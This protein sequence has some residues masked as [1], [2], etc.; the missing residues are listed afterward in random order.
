MKGVAFQFKM[1]NYEINGADILIEGNLPNG[2]GLSSSASIELLMGVILNTLFECNIDRR[3]MAIMGRAAENDFVGMNCGVMD[4]Y[5]VAMGK[6]DCAL[7]LNC[8][9]ITHEYVPLRID[10]YKLIISNTNVR[11]QLASSEYNIRRK[12]S[13][14]ALKFLKQKYDIQYLCQLAP[15][16]FEADK[17]M[18]EDEVARRRAE[19]AIY[20]NARVLEAVEALKKGNLKRFGV[21]MNLSHI[22]LRDLYEVTGPELDAMAEEAWK[23]TGVLGSRMTGGGFAG[24][25]V[26]L[27]DINS[28]D[29]FIRE[30]G[31]NYQ[32]RTG[33]TPDFYLADIG[34]GAKQFFM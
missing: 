32:R 9:K 27:V 7:L 12:E 23:I 29:E 30:V 24:C 11:H 22:S 21:L 1:A 28:V 19:H 33:L 26:S 3:E 34:D 20:E 15:E 13:E 10:G 17:N 2:A 5:A 4:Q 25:T 16:Q 31:K 18:I 14:R 6:K 8:N